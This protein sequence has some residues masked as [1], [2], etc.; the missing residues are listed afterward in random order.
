MIA[1][2]TN[3]LVRV[4]TRDD[5]AQ[6]DV[7]AGVMRSDALF[8]CASVLLELEWVLRFAYRFERAEIHGALVRLLG[9]P[10]LHVEA[11]ESVTEAIVA[12]EAG[13]DFADALHLFSCAPGVTEFATFDRELA[14]RA[15][16]IESAPRVRLVE[17]DSTIGG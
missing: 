2:D 4:L 1:L 9:L 10:T 8:V 6:A 14:K 16:R 17:G 3:I 13:M 5:P 12:Y 7:A 11:R 15:G